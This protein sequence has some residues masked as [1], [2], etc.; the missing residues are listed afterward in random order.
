M[1]L[2][3]NTLNFSSP[4]SPSWGLP[5]ALNHAE[6]SGALLEGRREGQPIPS[7]HPA[8]YTLTQCHWLGLLCSPAPPPFS[9]TEPCA[10]CPVC[11]EDTQWK[12]PWLPLAPRSVAAR[13]DNV[14]GFPQGGSARIG[15]SQPE[16][17]DLL[18]LSNPW[19]SLCEKSVSPSTVLLK[20]TPAKYT[21]EVIRSIQ[22]KYGVVQPGHSPH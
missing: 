15:G 6:G 17:T 3:C 9:S 8:A 10:L 12:A 19:T 20:L 7:S 11:A 18:C 16:V 5:A 14:S 2:F 21:D 4:V 22:E 13:M 1:L